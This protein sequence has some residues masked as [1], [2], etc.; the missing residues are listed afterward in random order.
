MAGSLPQVPLESLAADD[1]RE[2]GG[3][4]L[5][6]RLGSGGMGVAFLAARSGYPVLPVALT[7]TED[8]LV[9]PE[10]Y[11]AQVLYRWGDPVGSPAGMP[12]FRMDASNSADEQALQ[13]GM[14]HDGMVF[15]PLD[16]NP[17]HG[18]LA[19]NHEYTDDG[20]LHTDGMQNWKIGRAHV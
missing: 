10:G 16:G 17:R 4:R 12:A 18:L 11:V 13:A 6:G 1:P 8:R 19:I 20:L 15:F 9:V 2:V 7:G 5:L 3:Y 14:H